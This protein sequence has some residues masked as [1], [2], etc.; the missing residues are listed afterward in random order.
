MRLLAGLLLAILATGCGDNLVGQKRVD[1]PSQMSV[2]PSFGAQAE[3]VLQAADEWRTATGGV[4]D[5]SPS[6][7]N[8]GA[9]KVR[10]VFDG[11]ADYVGITSTETWTA[12]VNIDMTTLR[13]ESSK[14]HLSTDVELK[15]TVMHELGHA[16]GIGHLPTGL[17]KAEGYG[18]GCVDQAALDAFCETYGCPA[19]AAPTCH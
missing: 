7:G 3:I 17:M 6:I 13:S 19:S 4:A 18:G 9:V 14:Q 10:Q 11:S 15:D 12:N 16:F 2:S 1:L 5:L 8:D